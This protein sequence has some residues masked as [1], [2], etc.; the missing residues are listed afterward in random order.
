MLGV[1]IHN[2]STGNRGNFPT[3]K[4]KSNGSKSLYEGDEHESE[5]STDS[6]DSTEQKANRSKLLPSISLSAIHVME[7]WDCYLPT[8]KFAVV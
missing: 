6:E 7:L 1:N 4:S 8:T 2:R 3:K 5:D